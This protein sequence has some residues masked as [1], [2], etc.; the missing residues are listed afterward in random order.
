M[1]LC[2]KQK[3]MEEIVFVNTKNNKFKKGKDDEYSILIQG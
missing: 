1:K 3:K 2:I